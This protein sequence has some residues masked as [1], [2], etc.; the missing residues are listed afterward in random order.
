MT[1]AQDTWAYTEDRRF[2]FGEAPNGQWYVEEWIED[3]ARRANWIR[4]A[5]L[6]EHEHVAP[7]IAGFQAGRKD[8]GQ[9]VLAFIA[10][11]Y[12]IHD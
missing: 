8:V 10:E 9:S 4:Q 6:A 11:E 7:W 5:A 12:G 1:E 2:R 3:G